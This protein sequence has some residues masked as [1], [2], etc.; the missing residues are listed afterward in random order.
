LID[1]YLRSGHI[2]LILVSMYQMFH[3]KVP[4]WVVIAGFDDQHFYLHDSDQDVKDN[5]Y[6]PDVVYLPVKRKDFEQMIYF[7]KQKVQC[8]VFISKP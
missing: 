8:A 6:L 4:H 7:G 5:Q 3:K 1:R 2:P